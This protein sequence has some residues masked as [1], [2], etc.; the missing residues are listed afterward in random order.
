MS[1]NLYSQLCEPPFLYDSWLRVARKKGA[2]GVDGQEV[3]D[4]ASSLEKNIQKIAQALQKGNYE[5]SPLRSVQIPKER[6]GTFRRLGIPT[7]QDRV[8]FQGVNVLLQKLWTPR[9]S[10]FSFAYRPGA[11]VSDAI[12]TVS[13]F[14]G[15]GKHWFVKGDIRGCFDSLDWDILSLALKEWLAD[16]PLRGLINKALRVPVV[17]Q[18]RILPRRKGVPQGS[19]LSPVLAN[20]YLYPFD[21]EMTYQRFP[22]IRYGDDWIVLLSSESEAIEGFQCASAALSRILVDINTEKSGIGSL[23]EESILFLGHKIGASAIDAGPNGWKRFAK[24]LS[25]LKN[26]RNPAEFSRARAELSHL[27]SFYRNVGKIG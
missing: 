12:R 11:G 27:K 19:P 4:F 8:V 17:T 20:L 1:A 9:F 14:V 23:E 22:P 26:A 7:I 16:E 13:A 15:N 18:G 10:P 24:A 21:Y 3:R 5:P 2:S 25:D 6:R